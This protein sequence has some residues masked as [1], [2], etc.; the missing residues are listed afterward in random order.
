MEGVSLTEDSLSSLTLAWSA[1]A[2]LWSTH[3][4]CDVHTRQA[5]EGKMVIK[6][7]SNSVPSICKERCFDISKECI[8]W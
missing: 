1:S 8:K 4:T 2:K 7:E 6:Y 3:T 5:V